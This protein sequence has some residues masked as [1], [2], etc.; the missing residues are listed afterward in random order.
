MKNKLNWLE[1]LLLVAPL[2]A[3]AMLWNDLPA[4]VPVHWNLRGEINGWASKP[5]ALLGMPLVSIAIIAL[6]HVLPRFDPKLRRTGG[7]H[8]RMPRVLAIVRIALA[9]LFVAIFSMQIAATLGRPVAADRIV[10]T[11][12]LLFL[13]V[14]GNYLSNLRPNYFIGIRTPW[15]LESTETWRATHRL[16]GYLT[17]YGALLLLA[18]QFFVRP[19]IFGIV[20]PGAAVLLAIWGVWYSWHHFHTHDARSM[21]TGGN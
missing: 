1:G 20:V 7:T 18:L 9:A 15:T 6:L 10:P 5:V 14:I 17:F 2:V 21:E 11:T 3:V 19:S 8:G 4:R 12:L 13:A 16:G